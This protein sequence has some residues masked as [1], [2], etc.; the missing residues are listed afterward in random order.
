MLDSGYSRS[1]RPQ[2]EW[3]ENTLKRRAKVPHLFVCY[4]QPA[5][6]AG[7]KRDATDIQREWSPLFER[8]RVT[9]V[10]ENDHHIF[11]R[12]HPILKGKVDET[13]GIPYLGAGAW[14]VQTRPL[15]P[16][17]VAKRPW[18]ANA[19]SINHL[20]I[21]ETLDKGFRATAKGFDGEI[22]DSY[23]RDW[24]R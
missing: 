19:K 20:Y 3:L 5:Y 6:G 16:A 18:I 17:E 12:S 22:I 15:D 4:H 21:V 23:Q 13:N 14:S 8:Y 24:R 7:T 2:N 1:I 10:F 11:T 9:A